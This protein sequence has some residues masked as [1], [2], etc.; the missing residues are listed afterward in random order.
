MGLK[1]IKNGYEIGDPNADSVFEI[2]N[3]VKDNFTYIESI[4]NG[5]GSFGPI[6]PATASTFNVDGFATAATA[7]NYVFA[8]GTANEITINVTSEEL[9]NAVV[10]IDKK[11]AA[12]TKQVIDLG[13]T[14]IET[15]D[16]ITLESEEAATSRG[17]FGFIKGNANGTEKKELTFGPSTIATTTLTADRAYFSDVPVT[18][19]GVVKNVKLYSPANSVLS[20]KRYSIGATAN[21]YVYQNELEVNIVAGYNDITGLNFNVVQGDIIAYYT[22]VKLYSGSNGFI[23]IRG[24]SG[25]L[26]NTTNLTKDSL[27]YAALNIQIQ[28]VIEYDKPVFV[29]GLLS[30]NFDK[31]AE[32]KWSNDKSTAEYVKKELAKNTPLKT[33][34]DI[35]MVIDYGQSLA[36]NTNA[37]ASTFAAPLPYVI[38]TSGVNVN[39]QDM[40]SGWAEMFYE[41]GKEYGVLPIDFKIMVD[42]AGAGGKA[43]LQLN[44]GT[45]YYNDFIA[46]IIA[47]KAYAD[48]LNKTFSVFVNWTQGEEEYRCG[49]N[50]SLYGSGLWIATDYHLKI[51]QLIKDINDDLKD[52]LD[53]PFP[54]TLTCDQVGSHNAYYRYPTIAHQQLKASIED[55]NII[56]AKTMYD[57]DYNAGDYAHAPSKSYRNMGNH[58]GLAAFKTVVLGQKHYPVFPTKL[59]IIGNEGYLKFHVDEKP[60]QFDVDL[61]APLP[62]GNFGIDLLNVQN[63]TTGTLGTIEKSSVSVVS[64]ELV[65][66]D[67]VKITFS[68]P[69]PSG[70]R[71]T[72]GVNGSMWQ[73]I[74]G[75]GSGAVTGRTLGARGNLRDSRNYFNK[76][77]N[78]FYLHNFAPL[79]EIVIP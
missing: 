34:T 77:D 28:M 35:V 70:H 22:P 42:R 40:S 49:G 15:T 69:P 21:D 78:Y 19:T 54:V 71:L 75:T 29:D 13:F 25:Y 33:V 3:A 32:E 63:E 1:P 5:V 57:L 18:E 62:D 24:K 46:K 27:S 37:G 47:G 72:Y 66:D 59:T 20:I 44:K 45:S 67:V 23:G 53:Q 26:D 9:K 79:F 65:K 50:P 6:T 58:Y 16:A 73:D 52:V 41:L 10:K 31:T 51:K 55:P 12:Y 17:V 64:V 56:L 39:L 61:I 74:D 48:S 7:G 68:A 4:L 76:V 8:P 36:N 60:L 43:I 30:Q 38:N 2:L 11:G 14:N